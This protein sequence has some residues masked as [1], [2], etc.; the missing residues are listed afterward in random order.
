MIDI[1]I[2][3]RHHY[4]LNVFMQAFRRCTYVAVAQTKLKHQALQYSFLIA[5]EKGIAT[6]SETQKPTQLLHT[7]YPQDMGKLA[8]RAGFDGCNPSHQLEV[9]ALG[10]DCHAHAHI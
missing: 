8:S 4:C 2:D 3:L 7:V 5:S 1:C 9:L 6:L 10:E